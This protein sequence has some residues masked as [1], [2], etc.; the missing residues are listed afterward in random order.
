MS[1]TYQLL[2]QPAS[3][4]D[5]LEMQKGKSAGTWPMRTRLVTRLLLRAILFLLVI[6]AAIYLYATFLAID[7]P[8]ARLLKAASGPL[9]EVTFS[10]GQDLASGQRRFVV[11]IPA[12]SPNPN[13]CK[14][15]TSA[16]A[17]GYPS[18][19]VVNWEETSYKAEGGF[20]GPYLGKIS[21][22]LEYLDRVTLP[23]ANTG[24]K[25]DDD[26]L[27]LIVD[28]YDVWFQLP[29]N[30][31]LHRYHES[32]KR[33]NARLAAQWG[34]AGMPMKQTIVVSAQKRCFPTKKEGSNLHCDA[35]PESDL[36]ADAY[37]AK[38]DT[39]INDYHTV[40]PRYMNSG[41]FMG[42]A[43]DMKRYFRRVKERLEK[44]LAEDL[45]FP[46]DQ[47]IFA[48]IFGEQEVWR[49]WRRDFHASPMGDVM[50]DNE[51]AAFMQRDV[52]FHVGLDYTQ[53]LFL[54]TVYEENDGRF[55]SLNNKSV[56]EQHSSKLGISPV[57]L[58]GVPKDLVN[59]YNPLADILP[60]ANWGDMPLYADFFTA[61]VPVVLHHN[62]WK[63]GV[64][65]RRIWWWD[66]TWY[67]PHLRQL[68]E[69]HMK[70]G[71]LRPLAKLPARSGYLEYFAP[72]SDA[73]MRKP[74]AFNRDTVK[75]GFTEIELNA[76][77]RYEDETKDSEE[78][79]YNEVFRDNK[80]P[81]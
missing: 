71:K 51:G 12:D 76:V 70:P 81:M 31:L 21:G 16:I 39:N 28:A 25:L 1:W 58:L 11:V 48:E 9:S 44:G 26:D 75:T 72:R 77:C 36:P 19:V 35:L 74:R 24:D 4:D 38:T 29:P 60:D 42:P 78:H 3:V 18:P 69:L 53:D 22:T 66:Q 15:I 63:D 56:I 41:S 46:G 65:K 40:R 7:S 47:G 61:A 57:H 68:L 73:Q 30:M 5:N 27:V 14:L 49:Q 33:A 13:L 67:F 62:A 2:G 32:N 54:P 52:E 23:D 50:P 45:P 80:G 43:G 6:A 59:T 20:W 64:K 34:S 10:D 8:K 17:L 79:W 55:I 37:G